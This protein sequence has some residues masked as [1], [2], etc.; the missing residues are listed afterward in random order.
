M[1][2]RLPLTTTGVTLYLHLLEDAWRQ[3]VLPDGNTMPTA[4]RTSIHNAIRTSAAFTLIADLLFFE[5][6]LGL[7]AIV[8]ICQRDGNSNFHIRATALAV[9]V[10]KMTSTTKETAEEVKRVMPLLAPLALLLG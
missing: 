6:E 1:L 8:R 9:L 3:H 5:L 4:G 10:P 2:N 7:M